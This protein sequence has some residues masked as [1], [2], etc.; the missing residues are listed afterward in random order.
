MNLKP[1]DTAPRDGTVILG[2]FGYPWLLA[3]VWNEAVDQWAVAELQA[4][5]YEGQWNDRYFNTEHWPP[6][7]L[8]GW[9]ELPEV[10]G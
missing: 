1:P 10:P 5:L 2:H 7:K 9:V 3:T 4:D 6:D 8:L